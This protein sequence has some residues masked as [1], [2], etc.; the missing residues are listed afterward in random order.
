MKTKTLTI[1][2][3]AGILW[4]G[5]KNPVL[6]QSRANGTAPAHAGAFTGDTIVYQ[7]DNLIIRRLSNHIYVHISYLNTNTFGR[8]ECN[9]MIVVNE[10]EAIVFDTPADDTSSEEMIHFIVEKLRC[11]IKAVIPTHFHEDC[12]AGL[13]RFIERDIPVYTSNKTIELLKDKSRQFS[14]PIN[15][16]DGSISLDV[17]GKTVKAAYFGE[18]HTIDNIVGYFAEDSAIFGGC[19]IKAAG[20]S[21]G[22]LEDANVNAWSATVTQLKQQYPQAKIVIPGHGKPGGA[23]LLDY[24]IRLFQE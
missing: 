21:K 4:A 17:G 23:E 20:A 22:N 3:L 15:G 1:M 9:G 14:K 2:L 7:T 13:E 6:E 18:G 5:C 11:N 8:V 10:N 12:V 24:T 16:F 19:L